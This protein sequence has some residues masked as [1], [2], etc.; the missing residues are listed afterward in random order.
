M[1][2][3]LLDLKAYAK[4]NLTLDIV[5]TREDGYH[6]LE[7]VFHEIPIYDT[8][9][10][11]INHDGIIDVICTTEY[12]TENVP[13]RQDNIA[14]KTAKKFFEAIGD[15]TYGVT[16]IILKRIPMQA[17]MGGGS[18]DAGCILKSLNAMFENP[19]SDERLIQIAST[20][21]ADVPFFI[22]G[23]TAY[24]TNIGDVIKPLKPLPKLN[25]VVAK[26]ND[27]IS[28]IEAYRS[29]DALESIEHIDNAKALQCIENQDITELC[30]CCGNVFEQIPLPKE[31]STIK[32]TMLQCN[33][34]CSVM[35][36]SGS[37]VFGI[38]NT[39]EEAKKCYDTLQTSTKYLI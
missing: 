26:G 31:V 34:L 23:G 33:A 4:V 27:G 5:G 20:I 25:M 35:T 6:L 16:I 12:P 9:N 28:T 32:D 19:L 29:I 17:G 36:G 22:N 24:A 13:M 1:I 10:L 7:S 2:V 37:A 39:P 11:L 30:K 3:K 21:G 18:S 38:F 8:I 15:T 14:Y